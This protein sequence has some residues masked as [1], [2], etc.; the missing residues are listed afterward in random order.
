M[1]VRG[2]DGE[3]VLYPVVETIQD[4]DL[5][6]CREVIAPADVSEYVRVQAAEITRG[7]IEA[8]DGLGALGVELF[9]LADGQVAIN[10][11]A[12]R[13]HNSAHYSIEACWTSQF[14]NHVRAVLGFRLGD[15]SLRAE[16]AVMVN[17]L[18]NGNAPVDVSSDAL[19]TQRTYV[20]VYGKSENRP[21]RKMGHATALG[22]ST[23]EAGEAA[24]HAAANIK[25]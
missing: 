17:L 9:L 1:A 21:G 5:H 23:N 2:L 24:R 25:L 19:A 4:P 7:A 14:E 10:E 3:I 18:G 13:P 8:I 15:A 16:A 20:H 22:A 11:L 12:P 6:I